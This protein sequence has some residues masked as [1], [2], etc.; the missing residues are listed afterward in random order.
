VAEEDLE[1]PQD[2]PH[3]DSGRERLGA[4]VRPPAESDPAADSGVAAESEH[5]REEVAVLAT[6]RAEGEVLGTCPQALHPFR[7]QVQEDHQALQDSQPLGELRRG[8]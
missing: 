2:R 8:R 1:G 4:Q 3:Q 7:S 5:H 6:E